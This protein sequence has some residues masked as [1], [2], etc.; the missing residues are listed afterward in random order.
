MKK[1]A[2]VTAEKKLVI[3]PEV[4]DEMVRLRGEFDSLIETIE[5]LNDRELMEG[6]KRSKEDV[7]SGRVYKVKKIED[8]DRVLVGDTD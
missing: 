6:I 2:D 7:K 1:L 5:I 8:L 3:T 4:F